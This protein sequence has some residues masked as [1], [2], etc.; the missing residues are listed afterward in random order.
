MSDQQRQGIFKAI[1]KA[2]PELASMNS[3]ELGAVKAFNG[4]F[5]SFPRPNSVPNRADGRPAVLRD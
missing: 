1:M 2:V 3:K 4:D 5:L